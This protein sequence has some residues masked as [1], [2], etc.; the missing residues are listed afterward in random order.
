MC[1]TQK[2]ATGRRL[3]LLA[4]LICGI[5]RSKSCQLPQVV[6]E[7]P[8]GALDASREKQLHRLIKNESFDVETHFM[9]FAQA[10]ISSLSQLPLVLSIDAS[11][12]GR[13]YLALVVAVVYRQRALPVAWLVVK[14][15]KGHLPEEVHIRLLKEVQRLIPEDAQVVLVG[16][17]EF[18]GIGLQAIISSWKWHY[19]CRTACNIKLFWE[20]Q[21]FEF[22][23]MLPHTAPGE[24]F[25]APGCTFTSEKYGPVL[26]L[27]WWRDDCEE[28]IYLVSN[29][30]TPEEACRF[31]AKRFKIETLFS[32]KKSRGFNLHKSHISDPKRLSRLMIAVCLAYHWMIY[33]GI[34]A[35]EGGWCRTIH[36]ADRCDLSLFQLGLRLLKHFLKSGIR[37]PYRFWNLPAVADS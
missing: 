33:L 11:V 35:T 4:G 19:S 15:K 32:D 6:Q 12:V 28:P 10:L 2:R 21:P 18:D 34:L 17:G 23:D 9:P 7:M 36:R 3:N 27:C 22:R 16:D 26:A 5:I 31:Y 14:G 29:L 37:I 20:D 13:G 8:G 25:D 1:P 30:H 24:C